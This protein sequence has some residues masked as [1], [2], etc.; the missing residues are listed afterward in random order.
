MPPV[1]Y[2]AARAGAYICGVFASGCQAVLRARSDWGA[3]VDLYL[4][5][6]AQRGR[7]CSPRG[8]LAGKIDPHCFRLRPKMATKGSKDEKGFALERVITYFMFY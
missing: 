5:P 7:H 6:A 1:N 4:Q 8:R 2:A 3:P